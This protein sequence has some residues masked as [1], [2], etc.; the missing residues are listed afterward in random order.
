MNDLIFVKFGGSIITDK[1]AREAAN[2]E[3]I[4]RLAEEIRAARTTQ[5]TCR[6]LIGHGSGSFGHHF[7]HQYGVHKGTAADADWTGFALTSNAALRLNRIVVD[8]LLAVGVP[9]LALQPSTSLRSE[10]GKITAWQTSSIDLALMRNLVPVIHG[11]VAFDTEQGSAIISTETL[12]A[13][14][15]EHTHLRPTRI[16]LVGETAVYTADPFVD[17]TAQPITLINESNIEDILTQAGDSRSADVTGGMH[18]KIAEMW[19]LVQI[20]PDLKIQ[21]ISAEPGL[22]TRALLGDASEEGTHIQRT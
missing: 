19:H 7:A 16:I 3:V 1:S 4:T 2:M 5:P 14:L 21:L 9:A 6:L 12:F 11:D 17:P 22:L 20:V 18:S 13:Y 15:A 8:A 10:A